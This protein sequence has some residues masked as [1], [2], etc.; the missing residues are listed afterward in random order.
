MVIMLSTFSWDRNVLESVSL[1]SG[2]F[3]GNFRKETLYNYSLYEIS[4]HAMYGISEN[5]V[6]ENTHLPLLYCHTGD[7]LPC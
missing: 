4:M 2:H 6:P 7:T 3:E 1:Y 5:A